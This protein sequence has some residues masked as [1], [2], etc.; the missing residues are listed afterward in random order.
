MPASLSPHDRRHDMCRSS[1]AATGGPALV[2]HLCPPPLWGSGQP[3]WRKIAARGLLVYTLGG[4]AQGMPTLL[5][6]LEL[7]GRQAGAGWLAALAIVRLAPYVI[8]SPVVGRCSS[9]SNRAR[10]LLVTSVA[11]AGLAAWLSIA[12]AADVSP[13]C[14]WRRCLF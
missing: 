6:A 13:P 12:I 14:W 1:K 4:L 3:Q 10:F 5:L 11:R 7:D 8:C 2:G 9:G